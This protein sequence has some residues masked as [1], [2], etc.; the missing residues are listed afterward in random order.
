VANFAVMKELKCSLKSK[1]FSRI[2][3]PMLCLLTGVLKTTGGVSRVSQVANLAA[4]KEQ[5]Y[6]LQ[7]KRFSRVQCPMLCLLTGVLKTTGGRRK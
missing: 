1:V 4:M 5:E 6:S 3:C 7:S 2:Q